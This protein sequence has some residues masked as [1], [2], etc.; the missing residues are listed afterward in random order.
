MTDGRIVCWGDITGH[1]YTPP[2]GAFKQ[3]AAW[4]LHA[5]AVNT[6]DEA[7]CW[8][9]NGPYPKTMPPAGTF[10]QVAVGDNHSCGLKTD[11]QLVCWGWDGIGEHTPPA[12]TFKQLSSAV[13]HSCAVR[14]DGQLACWG[15]NTHGQTKPP[16]GTFTQVSSGS[17]FSCAVRTDHQVLCWG[18]D[19]HGETKPENPTTAA[20]SPSN[21]IL[22]EATVDIKVETT[23][24]L[25]IQKL[26]LPQGFT[27]EPAFRPDH[28]N[29]QV[30][31]P[32]NMEMLEV[33]GRFSTPFVPWK[34]IPG[35]SSECIYCRGWPNSSYTAY[36]LTSE[37]L[38]KSE[39][40][41]NQRY[42]DGSVWRWYNNN[43]G[44]PDMLA[45]LHRGSVKSASYAKDRHPSFRTGEFDLALGETS[46]VQIGLYKWK[47]GRMTRNPFAKN[48][49]K[50]VYTLTV[51]RPHP[52]SK[53]LPVENV[54][55][56]PT[57]DSVTA[58]WDASIGGYPPNRYI[59]QLKSVSD[60]KTRTRR[61][62]ADQELS[63]TFDAL[64]AEATYQVS[65]RARN[66]LGESAWS[67]AQV[68][69]PTTGDLG[70]LAISAGS[71]DFAPA[72]TA[73]TVNVEHSVS[74]VTLTPATFH[75]D[76]SV[77]VDGGDPTAAVSLDYG[78][79]VIAV[80]I[81]APDGVATKTYTVTVN[82]PLPQK[83]GP[84]VN[85]QV[86]ASTDT[87]TVTWQEPTGGDDPSHYVARLRDA[88]GGTEELR[89]DADARRAVFDGL[90][91]GATY[92]VGVRA[93][94]DGGDSDWSETRIT[95]P[96][97]TD[98]A[99]LTISEGSLTFAY[100][101][102]AYT[103]DVPRTVDSVTLTTAV[104]HPKATVTVDGGDPAAPVSLDYGANIIAV[105]VTAPD[106][107]ATQTYTVTVNRELPLRPGPPQNARV[108]SSADAIT[109]AWQ[110]P[111][112][113]DAPSHYV[114]RLR[115]SDGGA[116]EV[117]LD[118]DAR[119]AV[120]DGLEAGATYTVGVRAVNDGGESDWAE[121]EITLP[122][123]AALSSLMLIRQKVGQRLLTTGGT[124]LIADPAVTEYRIELA[125]DD[126]Y[127]TLRPTAQRPAS[128]AITV[129]GR[130][131]ASGG[132]VHVS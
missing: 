101:T 99:D 100:A 130:S 39:S 41:W 85:G 69:L 2:A 40:D 1:Y 83:P 47:H 128:S 9:T 93:G 102:T 113:G 82:R 127:L 60:G 5:C 86:E 67:H 90:D 122:L 61:I 123:P 54:R 3:V 57:L 114:A 94:N 91:S 70:G 33:D 31:V 89:L 45:S 56:S 132:V 119:R 53:P 76:A 68:T 29:Y 27:I 35:T 43:L 92:T 32:S 8:G 22:F 108:E 25:K 15:W 111:T 124:N 121:S 7:V 11:G 46:T 98:L 55:L 97:V 62:K 129:N 21:E 17:Y 64:D 44:F 84:P 117:R 71:L 23:D 73:Y 4:W 72:T 110:P 10:K 65:V 131:V 58:N 118:A 24:D 36:I 66:E 50:Q 112:G 107:V 80:V 116:E 26:T 87:I 103:V 106:G 77:T 74:S 48:T 95:L 115:D 125:E 16:A 28:Y 104:F 79:N 49:T 38:A 78:A 18:R 19:E 88:D 52:P 12:G 109:I 63:V 75:S 120:F 42:G 6:D 20:A 37:D 59:I 96:E 13:G 30:T 126:L 105:V 34:G 81:T 51:T 14:T